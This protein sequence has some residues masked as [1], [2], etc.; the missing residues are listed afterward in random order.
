MLTSSLQK[1]PLA[2][3][4]RPV[5]GVRGT[6]LII[7]LPGSPKGAVENLGAILMVLPHAIELLRGNNPTHDILFAP[8]AGVRSS[9][10]CFVCLLPTIPTL[11]RS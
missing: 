9:G 6:S 8:N 10:N 3:L 5:C 7:T 11:G 4:S 2:A 1:T